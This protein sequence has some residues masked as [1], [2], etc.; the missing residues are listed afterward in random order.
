[1]ALTA[2]FRLGPYEFRGALGAG[3]MGEVYRARDTKL[4]RDV[5]LK[6]LPERFATDPDRLARFHRE[7]HTLASLSHP[8]IAAIH[9]LEED[10]SSHLHALVLELVEG[11]T[12]A[13]RLMHG[14][15]PIDESLHIARQ[16]VDALEAAHEK[17]IVHRD[18]KPSNIKVRDDGAVKV[19]D[20]GLAKM[21]D[22]GGAAEASLAPTIT[23]PALTR[24]GVVLGTA[25]YMAP[26]QARGKFADSRAD[27][28]A[29]GVIVYEMVT[30]GR[31]FDGDTVGEVVS[32]VLKSEPEWAR[33]PADT[34]APVRRLLRR[35]LQKDRA[36]RLRSIA[37]ARFDLEAT[38]VESLANE[39]GQRQP[40]G[41]RHRLLVTA[42]VAMTTLAAVAGVMLWQ[43]PGGI[44]PPESRLEISTAR[45]PGIQ[46]DLAISPDGLMVVYSAVVEGQPSLWLRAIDSVAARKLPGTEN[47]YRP[48]WSADGRSVH[49]FAGVQL[50]TIDLEGGSIRTLARAPLGGGGTSNSDAV[51]LF[52]A[53]LTA[54]LS[55]L[56]AGDREPRAAT[57]LAAK[58]VGHQLPSFLPDGRHYVYAVQRADGGSSIYI[59]DIT[60]RDVERSRYL[61]DAD[62]AAL[63]VPSRRLL[64]L[65]QGTLFSQPFDPGRLEMSGTPA[66]LAER[67]ASFS[68]SAAG[69]IAYRTI[70]P[71]VSRQFIWFDRTG[72]ALGSVGEPD[73][74]AD[75]DLSPDGRTIAMARI[76]GGNRDIWL[77]DVARGVLT[78]FT[79]DP[80]ADL[81]PRWS[82]DGTRIVFDSNREDVYDLYVKTV[83]GAAPEERL[84]R[85]AQSKSVT[86]W[87]ADY[88]LFRSVDPESS[89]NLWALP[90]RDG[91]ATP[92]PVV[93]GDFVEAYGQL[94]PD[95][96]WIA[97]QSDESGRTEIYARPF[98][99]SGA[100]VR[101]STAGGGQ[102][103]WR[104]DGRE[105]IYVALDG[106][107]MAVP[108]QPASDGGRMDA[109]TP[110]ALFTTRMG[111]PVPLQGGYNQRYMMVPDATKFLIST[112]I[113]D[114][115]IAPITVIQNWRPP[116]R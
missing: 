45:S 17:G 18:L 105:L 97:Y 63:H 77:L 46:P 25:A 67:V 8:N 58:Q 68:A 24:S 54:P 86:Q 21:M 116:N 31:P 89:H 23:S 20:F 41:G 7:A 43:Q 114:E 73:D 50:K 10:A 103:R 32:E 27:I 60:E 79:T 96:K 16:I 28:W 61:L 44:A 19:L 42:L 53:T 59:G 37:D 109:G 93:R 94:S 106:R 55:L 48:F 6:I 115:S 90:M 92:F 49:F 40:G 30:G 9:G 99:S 39:T 69:P 65:R 112:I 1:M 108:L 95:G 83:T 80:A 70:A 110:V 56:G 98:R 36:Q 75:P 4:Q 81:S 107:L 34:P 100:Q 66:P 78:R 88:M 101:I 13:D 57:R 26:E 113:G 84:L 15:I 104:Q 51:N 91:D 29:F 35:C 72:H 5:A 74:P 2:G 47:A 111:D 76:Q 11:P 22:S 85:T 102:M 82:P 38:E 87:T 3:G 33:L 71:P 14:R 64:F 62:A 52:S 12:L